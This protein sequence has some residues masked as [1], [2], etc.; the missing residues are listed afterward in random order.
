[1]SAPW[2]LLFP[3]R[4]V[5]RRVQG[6]ELSLPWSHPLPDYARMRP[7]YGQNLVELAALLARDP[8]SFRFVDVGANVGDSTA[9]VLAR[10]GGR[11]LCVEGDPYWLDFLRTNVGADER[12]EIEDAL[13]VPAGE[14]AAAVSAVRGLG[15]THFVT[16][17]AARALPQVTAQQLRERHPDFDRPQLVKSDTDG[18]DTRL[19]PAVAAAWADAAPV[20]FFEFDPAMTRSVA[21]DDPDA[22]WPALAD[23]G[24]G[25][26]A[27]WDNTG[28]VLGRLPIGEAAAAAGTL[29]SPDAHPGYQFWDVA[30]CRSDDAAALA[31]FAALAPAPFDPAGL[32]R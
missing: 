2:R 23:L 9:Q 15:T 7:S 8:A 11:A 17:R 29:S 28:D 5:R 6:V 26:L 25:E 30:A 20:L 13:L 27:V 1:M 22:V 14:P 10:T 18:Y 3:H 32:G 19:V 4:A 12:V 16:A 21:G 31:A 24:Y